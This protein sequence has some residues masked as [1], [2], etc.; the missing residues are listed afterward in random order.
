[1]TKLVLL[2]T[3]FVCIYTVNSRQDDVRLDD[4]LTYAIFLPAPIVFVCV[5]RYS[6]YRF[7]SLQYRLIQI[8][9]HPSRW[10]KTALQNS[11]EQLCESGIVNNIRDHVKKR[12]NSGFSLHSTTK[13]VN[14]QCQSH[15]ATTFDTL[16][17]YLLPLEP[18][19][20]H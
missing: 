15:L 20:Q 18:R 6:R 10:A 4:N 13:S 8:Y 12:V 7:F 14:L 17:P 3:G 16:T 11:K 9:C 5:S 19:Y 2:I 1:M